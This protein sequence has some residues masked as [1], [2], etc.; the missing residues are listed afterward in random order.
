[1]FIE[2]QQHPTIEFDLAAGQQEPTLSHFFS[3]QVDPFK[4]E[5]PVLAEGG[6]EE[7]VLVVS[8]PLS[9]LLD[10]TIRLHRAAEFPDMLVVDEQHRAFFGAVRASLQQALAKL[11]RIQFAVLDDEEEDEDC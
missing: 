10:E 2:R 6:D 4:A 9:E 5:L 8:S 7:R 1:M 11:D 3:N